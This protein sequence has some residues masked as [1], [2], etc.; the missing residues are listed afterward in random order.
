LRYFHSAGSSLGCGR[1]SSSLISVGYVDGDAADPRMEPRAP[2]MER[3]GPEYWERE[4]QIAKINAQNDRG[5]LWTGRGRLGGA[6]L[7]DLQSL[8]RV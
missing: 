4:T 7:R 8:I 5:N 3:E 6:D 2:W 1:R